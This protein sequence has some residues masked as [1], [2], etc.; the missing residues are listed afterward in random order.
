[1][2]FK[3][4]RLAQKLVIVVE[5]ESKM[6][7]LSFIRC[8]NVI[9][10]TKGYR[11]QH[12]ESISNIFSISKNKYDSNAEDH[13]DVVHFRGVNLSF[14]IMRCVYNLYPRKIIQHYRLLDYRKGG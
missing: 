3:F 12:T 7:F 1:M 9:L 5:G 14:F 13:K 6:E 8:I 10:Q 11:N 2:N 4:K